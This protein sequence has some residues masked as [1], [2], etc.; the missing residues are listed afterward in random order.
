MLVQQAYCMAS[1]AEGATKGDDRHEAHA[2]MADE[3]RRGSATNPSQAL[4]QAV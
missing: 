3:E 4:R 2:P 1:N